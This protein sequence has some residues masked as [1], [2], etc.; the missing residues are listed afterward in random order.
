MRIKRLPGSVAVFWVGNGN[1]LRSVEERSDEV[2]CPVLAYSLCSL[3]P[4]AAAVPMRMPQNYSELP[5]ERFRSSLLLFVLLLLEIIG[6][7]IVSIKSFL[8]GG[9]RR[10]IYESQYGRSWG[11]SSSLWR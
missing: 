6:T 2:K 10:E 7:W 4:S 1:S 8:Y 3:T 9:G 11:L 5:K